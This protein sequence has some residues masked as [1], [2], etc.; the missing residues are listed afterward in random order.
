MQKIAKEYSERTLE[1]KIQAIYKIMHMGK[2][3][4]NLDGT[5]TAHIGNDGGFECPCPVFSG[6]GFDEPVSITYCYC[7][8]GHFRFHYQIALDVKLETITV[9]SSALASK[10]TEPCIFRYK[11]LK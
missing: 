7:C 4:L 11:I 9:E 10:R 3:V 5:I 1:D 2:P 8:A 6:S